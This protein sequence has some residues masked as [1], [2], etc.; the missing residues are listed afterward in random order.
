M[1]QHPIARRRIPSMVLLAAFVL[2]VPGNRAKP[3]P[4]AAGTNAAETILGVSGVNGGLVVVIGCG[5]PALLADLRKAGPYLV[6]GLDRNPEKVAATRAYLR[7]KGLYGPVTVSRLRGAELPCV[8]SLV[9]LIVV[10][11][12]T[13]VALEEMNRALAP[14]G[15]VA[16]VRKSEV[17]ITRKAWPAELD[18]WSHFLH[19]ASNNAVS[20][21]T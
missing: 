14:G 18:E 19:D 9:N 21:D 10:T 5:D 16:D 12:Q 6:H 3:E 1:T 17:R 13:G 2:L 4:A 11:G 8:D 15:A 20:K 7:K